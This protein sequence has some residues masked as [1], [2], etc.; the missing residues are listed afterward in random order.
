MVAKVARLLSLGR[1]IM[2]IGPSKSGKKL[3][4]RLAAYLLG[5]KVFNMNVFDQYGSSSL[6]VDWLEVAV[7]AGLR[8][9]R[10]LLLLSEQDIIDDAVIALLGSIASSGFQDKDYPQDFRDNVE[11]QLIAAAQDTRPCPETPELWRNFVSIVKQNICICISAVES[12]STLKARFS[13]TPKVFSGF[14]CI[15]CDHSRVDAF[16]ECVTRMVSTISPSPSAQAVSQLV[17]FLPK[18]FFIANRAIK[19]QKESLGISRD[20]H[21][22]DFRDMLSRFRF[23]FSENS[24]ETKSMKSRL[25]LV[26]FAIIVFSTIV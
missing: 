24:Q 10:V 9:E 11:A 26:R 12:S 5:Y 1:H 14:L 18:A 8:K 4:S 20:F 7:I 6:I 13:L 16:E 22:Q 25:Y 21:E 2:L 17:S 15:K 3:V 19:S 23:I